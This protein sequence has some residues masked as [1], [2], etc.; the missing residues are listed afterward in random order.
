MKKWRMIPAV[1]AIVALLTATGIASGQSNAPSRA[2]LTE[3]KLGV[4]PAADYTPL[5]VGLKR[6]IFKKHGLD[7][8]I[9]YIFTGSGL[10]AAVTS[11]QV[12]AGTNSVPAGVTAI[13]NGLP[14][15]LVV[16]TSITPKKG[17]INVLVKKDSSIRTYADL[18]GKTV[19]TINLQG[20][21]H[22]LL[23]NAIEKAGGGDFNAVPMSPADEPAALESGRLD[24]IV[25]QDPTLTL[26]KQQ[27]PAFRSLGNPT[28]KLGFPLPSAGFY[29]SNATIEKKPAAIKQF[30]AA[31][32]EAIALSA[33]NEK[34][35]RRVVPKFTGMTTATAKLVTLPIFDSR[36]SPGS[37]GPMLLL[38]KKYGWIEN[39]PSFNS[40]VWQGK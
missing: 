38:M 2:Q 27:Y 17:Y 25:M 32:K 8:K 26:A 5:F 20:Q 23:K 31:L 3:F 4:F 21:F 34:L 22:L 33:K 19:A 15:K 28:S 24:A 1:V 11:G 30:V 39:Q 40:I 16:Q 7:I 12:D 13:A 10:M 29:S 35:A 36:V 9:Q 18:A 6:G 14:I 37:I